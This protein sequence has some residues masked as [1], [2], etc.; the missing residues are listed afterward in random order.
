M[1][2]ENATLHGYIPR[3]DGLKNWRSQWLHFRESRKFR[4]AAAA[5]ETYRAA[6]AISAAPG[7]VTDELAILDALA[8]ADPAGTLKPVRTALANE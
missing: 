5:A 6:R 4:L 1:Q 2:A 8:V 7:T 3:P